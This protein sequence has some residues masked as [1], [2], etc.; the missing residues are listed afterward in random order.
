MRL[1]RIRR[2]KRLRGFTITSE[3][4]GIEYGAARERPAML[5]QLLDD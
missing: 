5:N 2:Q 4:L 1:S 3:A